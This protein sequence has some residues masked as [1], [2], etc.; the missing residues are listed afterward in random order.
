MKKI[1]GTEVNYFFVC[2]R[3]LWLSRHQITM[4]H[5]SENVAIGKQ[6]SE[7]SYLREEKEVRIDETIALDFV[8]WERKVVHEVK[9]TDKLEKAHEWQLLY[10]LF[11]LK[12]YKGLEGFTGILNY[13]KLKKT[14]E[15][16]LTCELEKEMEKVI[17][18]IEKLLECEVSKDF[19]ARRVCQACSYEEFCFA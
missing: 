6:I 10:Y 18:E 1:T 12:K 13:P 5:N 4:E 17:S 19:P 14:K 11:Y 15:V 2:K 16:F 9:K 7:N 3:K 8:D